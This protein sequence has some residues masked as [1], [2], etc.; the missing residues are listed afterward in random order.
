[1]DRIAVVG[2]T[3]DQGFGLA[4]RW[5]AAGLRLVIGS[6]DQRRAEEAVERLRQAVPAADVEGAENPGAVSEAG[7]AVVTVPFA[8]QAAIY[9]SIAPALRDDVV[10]VDCTVP[11]AAAVGAKATQTLGVWQGS[12]AGQAASFL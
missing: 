9:R 5:A 6:R 3:G 1:M 10:V 8:G 2:G 11:L 7:I 4:L 12:A